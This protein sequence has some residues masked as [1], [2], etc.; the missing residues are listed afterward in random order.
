MPH[1]LIFD[2]GLGGLSVYNELFKVRPDSTFTYLADDAVFPYGALSENALIARV[3]LLMKEYIPKLRPDCVVIAC[4]TASTL[5]LPPLRAQF[6]VP[7]IGT[8]PA[9]KTAAERTQSKM[10]S[11]LATPGTVKRDYTRDLISQYASDCAVTLVGAAHLAGI[12]ETHMC[13]EPVNLE[14]IAQEITPCF[15]EHKNQR[16]D[17]IV[18]ACTHYP[19]ILPLLQQ[20]SPWKVELINPAPAIAKR[21][22][23]VLAHMPQS[24]KSHEFTKL[25]TRKNKSV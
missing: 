1:I 9:I 17:C 6:N 5:V 13:G 12:A 4:N 18:L 2:S 23:S 15:V 14:L 21:V 22:A 8:V 20:L 11:V 7:F 24:A 25:F 10:F 16:T 19:L 3:L